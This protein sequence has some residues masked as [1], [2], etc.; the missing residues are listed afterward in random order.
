MDVKCFSQRILPEDPSSAGCPAASHRLQL[1]LSL[2]LHSLLSLPRC[3]LSPVPSLLSPCLRFA[4]GLSAVSCSQSS[5]CC[6]PA[7]RVMTTVAAAAATATSDADGV[8]FL[9][10][11]VLYCLSRVVWWSAACS[12]SL[13][14]RGA[15]CGLRGLR[16]CHQRRL[17]QLVLAVRHRCSQGSLSRV[18]C[19]VHR[20][21]GG[22]EQGSGSPVG[23]RCDTQ[24]RRLHSPPCSAI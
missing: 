18:L 3:A 16:S 10:A 1:A 9:I 24:H 21:K 14:Q 23:G 15:F 12:P 6:L 13:L 20:G 19:S 2:P 17:L 22:D 11:V 4:P 5:L 7:V 8:H